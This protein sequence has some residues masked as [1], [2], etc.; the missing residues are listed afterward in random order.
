MIG[1][2][3]NNPISKA[4]LDSTASS[5][6]PVL[7]YRNKHS[8]KGDFNVETKRV[9]FGVNVIW[10]SSMENVDRL[11]CDE[12][13]PATVNPSDYAFYQLF[14]QMILPGYWNY[15]IENADKQYLNIDLRFGFKF[16]ENL[17]ANFLV[18]N[19]LNAEYVGR[20]GDM[21]APRRYEIMIS[22]NF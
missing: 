11:F 8:I 17:R 9:T 10:R 21:H 6:S 3:Y 22:S 5:L 13:D 18:K 4:G 14:S 2:T 15:R 7:K 1:Y 20:P 12:R 16:S 19:A